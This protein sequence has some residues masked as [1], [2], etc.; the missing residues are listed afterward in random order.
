MFRK[1]PMKKL[2]YIVPNIPA[3]RNA[4]RFQRM[5]SLS[6]AFD[7]TVLLECGP[8]PAELNSRARFLVN[9]IRRK[10]FRT[11]FYPLWCIYKLFGLRKGISVV[12]SSFQEIPLITGYIGKRLTGKRWVADIYDF[13][14]LSIEVSESVSASKKILQKTYFHAVGMVSRKLLK[15]ADLVLCTLVPEALEKYRIQKHKIVPLTNGV[16]FRSL[17]ER[18]VRPMNGGAKVGFRVLYVGFVMRIRGIDAIVEA[19][20][21]LNRRCPGLEWLLVGKSQLEDEHWLKEQIKHRGLQKNISYLGELPHADVLDL[22]YGS[23]TC[24]FTFPKSAATDYIYPIK[25]FEYMAYGKAIVATGLKGVRQ[26][27]EHAKSALIVEPGDPEALAEAVERLYVDRELGKLLGENARREAL[28]YDWS[29]IN[30]KLLTAL[31]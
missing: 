25:I 7:L 21:L 6:G 19:A 15:R 16:D 10:L 9:P 8:V 29:E 31:K 28:K 5:L 24:L 23:D 4:T 2:V 30:R 20:A 1:E 3:S 18:T 17:P 27:L 14:G 26:V 12:I 11:L 13:P 22:I